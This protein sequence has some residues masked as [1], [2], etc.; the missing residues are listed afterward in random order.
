MNHRILKKMPDSDLATW[1][2]EGMMYYTPASDSELVPVAFEKS[3]DD[4]YDD[5]Q[6]EAYWREQRR[7]AQG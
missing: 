5:M 6:A 2:G 1:L 7:R 3:D 4:L